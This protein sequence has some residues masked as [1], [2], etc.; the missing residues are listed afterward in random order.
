MSAL[1]VCVKWAIRSVLALFGVAFAL[2]AA[3]VVFLLLREAGAAPDEEWGRAFKAI[4][5]A[6][7][8]GTIV[9]GATYVV[10]WLY[11]WS[12]S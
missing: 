1:K 11:R 8:L 3:L 4:L 2:S 10:E 9:T 6:V 5:A 7:A 12:K